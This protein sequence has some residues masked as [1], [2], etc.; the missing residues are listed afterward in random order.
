MESGWVGLNRAM[1]NPTTRPSR[2][3]LALGLLALVSASV[4]ATWIASGRIRSP[5]EA[6][7]RTVAPEPSPILV[8]VET[9]VISSDIVTRGTGRFGSP[10]TLT[11]AVSDLKPISGYVDSVPAIG[12]Q[13]EEGSVAVVV[14]GRPVVILKG[15]QPAFRDMG[16][17]MSGSDV[18]QL[19]LAL[20]RIGFPPGDTDGVYDLAT[21]L[22]V[23]A[24]HRSLGFAP[25]SATA[26]QQADI[27]A[28]EA[29]LDA[30]EADKLIAADS[31]AVARVDLVAAQETLR[32]ATVAASAASE[33]VLTVR[34]EADAANAAADA[35]LRAAEAAVERAIV[36]LP[37]DWASEEDEQAALFTLD[38][39]R[40]AQAAA[41]AATHTVLTAGETAITAAELAA[42]VA[43]GEVA[44]AA[45]VVAAAQSRLDLA[46]QSVDLAASPGVR[47][48]EDLMLA[49]QRAGIQVPADEII[50]VP[51]TP[52][53]VA[54]VHM[55]RG[56]LVEGPLLSVTDAVV[57]IDGSLALDQVRFV[58]PGMAVTIDEPDL[59]IEAAG[60]VSI[61]ADGPG[62]QGADGFHV[63]FETLVTGSVTP[64]P[65]IAGASVRLTLAVESSGGPVLTVP[66][67]AVTLSV[68][69]FSQVLVERGGNLETVTV[70][71]GLA[72]AGYV[73][74][75]APDDDLAV[76]DL[77]AIGFEQ[78]GS[79]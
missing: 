28:I 70:E 10:Q 25:V 22:A 45:S 38:E 71:P 46:L 37:P 20:E 63:Y 39:L 6:A 75:T 35:D 59:G 14:S 40:L 41:Q 2:I 5:A 68:D 30:I 36:L 49:T 78:W 12:D 79:Q 54:E 52:L 57:A 58:E 60:T 31:V 16:P 55:Q 19:E 15:V 34:A 50:F 9:R 27:R 76:G 13:L 21:Q 77:V 74:V 72:A 7:A 1:P 47:L 17:G 64:T 65:N 51:E 66:A 26:Q 42:E 29:D 33:A 44:S 53:R 4:A 69:G 48:E 43:P 3:V 24:W 18:L 56:D 32:A 73:A 11:I 23:S 67:S 62:T 8:P 61:V